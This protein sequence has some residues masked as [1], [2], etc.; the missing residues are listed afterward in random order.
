MNS[1]RR[2]SWLKLVSPWPKLWRLLRAWK[3][4]I[5]TQRSFMHLVA[6]ECRR[7]SFI[8]LARVRSAIA[9]VVIITRKI[10][11]FVRQI[12]TSVV[13]MG[14]L[15]PC[16]S[17]VTRHALPFTSHGTSHRRKKPSPRQ[18]TG[19][20]WMEGDSSDPPEEFSLFALSDASQPNQLLWN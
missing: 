1:F 13:N 16:A 4:L 20:K 7:K 19:T 10:V 12:A 6:L 11:R 9:V 5:K 2:G 18:P 14:I 17:Q 15:H 3:P 8:F